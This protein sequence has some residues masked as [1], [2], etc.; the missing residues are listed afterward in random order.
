MIL[1]ALPFIDV[2]RE[3]RL[4]RRPVAIIAAILTVLAMGTLTYKGATAKEALGSETIE[5]VPEWAE[6]QGFED[7][8]GGG[9][10]RR[11]LRGLRLPRSATPTSAPAAATSARRTS[12]RSAR[13]GRGPEY[14]KTYVANPAQFGNT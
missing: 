10:G 13:R 3:R 6:S 14:F 7:N 2:R 8:P 12:P 11:A 1:I 9:R 4:M 5:A